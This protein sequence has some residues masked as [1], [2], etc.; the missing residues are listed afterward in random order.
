MADLSNILIVTDLDGT[1][2]GDHGAPIERNLEAVER[3]KAQ[4]G[5]F[6]IAT[7]RTNLNLKHKWSDAADLVNAPVVGCNGAMLCDL[8]TDKMIDGRLMNREHVVELIELMV[9][10][11]PDLGARVSVEEGFLSSPGQRER[12]PEVDR[13]LNK[14]A[15]AKVFTLPEE[16]W[17]TI[18]DWYKVVVRGAIERTDEFRVVAEA[19]WPGRFETSKSGAAY[20][21]FQAPD[22]T[23]ATMLPALREYVEKKVGKPVKLYACGDY[24]NDLTMLAAA[25]VAVC[26]TN[27]LDCVKAI[28]DHCLCHHTEGLIASLIELIEEG[29]A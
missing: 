24:E 18:A 2:F 4:G 15:P 7:G 9:R 3:L 1:F 11:Y 25:D 13:D 8:R 19:K 22:T 12:C 20:L 27:A 6:T 21:E 5:H 10:D 26:P 28:A 14:V 16:E 23:K 17:T 29:K